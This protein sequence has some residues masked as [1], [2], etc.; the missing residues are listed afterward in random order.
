MKLIADS[1][2]DT[3]SNI[4]FWI[5]VVLFTAIYGS[6]MEYRSRNNAVDSN[7]YHDVF[8]ADEIIDVFKT[9]ELEASVEYIDKTL[10]INGVIESIKGDNRKIEI[11]LKDSSLGYRVEFIFTD[12]E[13]LSQISSLVEGDSISIVGILKSYDDNLLSNVLYFEECNYI[14]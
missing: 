5:I 7:I 2:R 4:F 11:S 6:Y 3:F 14:N 13:E 8:T 1:I 10:K 9:N 12:V